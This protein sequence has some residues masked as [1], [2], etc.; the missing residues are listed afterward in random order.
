MAKVGPMSDIP[1]NILK[2]LRKRHFL[3]FLSYSTVGSRLTSV[4]GR[5]ST[6]LGQ[7]DKEQSQCTWGL[8]D[9]ERW[10]LHKGY[11]RYISQC[12]S[13]KTVGAISAACNLENPGGYNFT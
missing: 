9:K 11:L 13:L 12:V 3:S 8:G 1:W 5:L 6:T 2:M 7:S 4:F 10:P